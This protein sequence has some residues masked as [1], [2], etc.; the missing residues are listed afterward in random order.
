MRP[1]FFARPGRRAALAL[2]VCA[3]LVGGCAKSPLPSAA[4][5]LF[6]E[7]RHDLGAIRTES[8][9]SATYR[10]TNSTARPVVVSEINTSCGCMAADYDPS[11]IPVGGHR[12]ITLNLSTKGQTLLG[13][14]VKH[15]WVRFDSGERVELELLARLEP[16]FELEPRTLT[17]S[18]EQ[19]EQRLSLVRK[20]LDP[21][22]FARLALVAAADRYAVRENTSTSTVD[23]RDFRI[24]LKDALAGATLPEIS[25]ADARD[26]KPRPFSTVHCFRSGPTLRPSAFVLVVTGTDAQPP[27][28]RFTLINAS[29]QE[30]RILGASCE[31]E[32]CEQLLKVAF[33]PDVDATSFEVSLDHVPKEPP[34]NLLIA[35]RYQSEGSPEGRL[36]LP[37]HIVIGHSGGKP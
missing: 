7:T 21:R 35:V 23:R 27:A 9:Y 32:E 4:R 34:G 30:L 8:D 18:A 15:A 2:W 22:T 5:Q 14:L 26:G 36:T 31:G 12:D 37:C 24:R 16:E 10:I 17:F 33:D 20:Q 13:P 29:S 28:Q 6:D 3:E 25:V 1:C 11:S 19:P